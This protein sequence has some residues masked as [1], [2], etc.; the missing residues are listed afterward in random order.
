[1]PKFIKGDEKSIAFSRANVIVRLAIPI[2]ASCLTS[3]PTIPDQ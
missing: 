3:S 2:S 1:M